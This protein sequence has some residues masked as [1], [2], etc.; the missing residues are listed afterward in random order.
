[1][2]RG[3]VILFVTVTVFATALANLPDRRF[4]APRIETIRDLL[5]WAKLEIDP[6]LALR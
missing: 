6:L 5:N 1:M 3:R 4:E 2:I